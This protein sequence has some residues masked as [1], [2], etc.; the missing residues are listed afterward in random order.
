MRIVKKYA[1]FRLSFPALQPARGINAFSQASPP[2]ARST[3]L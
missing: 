1:T 2:A 3:T